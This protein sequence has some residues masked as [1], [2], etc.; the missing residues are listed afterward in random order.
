MDKAGLASLDDRV[1][2]LRSY[3]PTNPRDTTNVD[4]KS[5]KRRKKEMRSW[6][7]TSREKRARCGAPSSSWAGKTATCT[8]RARDF[9]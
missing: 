1:D 4:R 2:D 6:C 8:Q 3:P 7:P 5:R 9:R